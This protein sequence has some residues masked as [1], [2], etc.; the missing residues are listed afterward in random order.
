MDRIALAVVIGTSLVFG[1]G[2]LVGVVVMVSAAI[3]RIRPVRAWRR[4]RPQVPGSSPEDQS[5]GQPA[6]WG[7]R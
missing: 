7:G 4:T 5:T 6:S 2:I 3:R 1:G